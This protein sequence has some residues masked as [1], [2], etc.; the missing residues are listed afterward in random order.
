M[1]RKLFADRQHNRGR[2]LGNEHLPER[3]ML[4]DGAVIA[5]VRMRPRVET[6][7]VGMF[8]RRLGDVRVMVMMPMSVAGVRVVA[9]DRNGFLAAVA[10]VDPSVQTLPCQRGHAVGN[11]DQSGG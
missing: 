1:F 4:A 9:R 8:V 5:I 3:L 2:R 6:G 7:V 11:Q 10:I